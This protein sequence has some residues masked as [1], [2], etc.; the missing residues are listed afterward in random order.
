MLILNPR[1]VTF[2]E[3]TWHAVTAVAIDRAPQRTALEWSDEGPYPVLA[4][5]P[6][7]LV[8]IKVVQDIAA[9][10]FSTPRPGDQ[11]DLTLHTS[12]HATDAGRLKLTT[13]AVILRV[14]HDLTRK[15]TTRTITLAAI[16]E[17][18]AADPITITDAA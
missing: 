11:A 9:G 13:T 8:T 6:E 3:S 18:G 12:P 1:T 10:D 7:Q 15:T 14:E 17:D 2:G 5:V 16:S 4:D